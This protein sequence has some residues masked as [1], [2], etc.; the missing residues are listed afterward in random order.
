[1]RK[2]AATLR[3]GLAASLLD[4]A[5]ARVVGNGAPFAQFN[6]KWVCKPSEVRAHACR[7]AMR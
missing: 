4:T 2:V 1:M 7:A 5:T 6:L 3:Y